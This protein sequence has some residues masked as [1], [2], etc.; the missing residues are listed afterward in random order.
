MDFKLTLT[1]LIS[2]IFSD[3][4]NAQCNINLDDFYT[5][6]SDEVQI[7]LPFNTQLDSNLNKYE[8]Q[9]IEF[10][11]IDISKSND[12]K[13]GDDQIFGPYPIGFNFTFYNRVYNEFWISSNG[14]ISFIEPPTT[15]NSSVIPNGGEPYASIMGAWE[16]WNPGGGG[17][18]FFAS[19]PSK[20]V[21]Q[22]FELNSYNCG[23]E[24]DTVGT[25]QIVLNKGTNF[26]DIHTTQK[27]ECTPS[28][29]GIQSHDGSYAIAVDGRNSS[30]WNVQNQSVRFKPLNM[31]YVNWF[32]ELGE[33]IYNGNPLVIEPLESQ[34]ITV[35]VDN[36][37]DCYFSDE[38]NLFVSIPTPNI[39]LNGS[40]LLCD[41]NGYQYQWYLNDEAIEN[42]NA[43]YFI[44]FINGSYT[45]IA[46]SDIGCVQ[47]SNPLSVD[48]AS[49]SEISLDKFLNIY[50][51]P[52]NGEL[53]IH[54]EIDLKLRLYDINSRYLESFTISKDKIKKLNLETGI[55]FLKIYDSDFNFD[56]R[57]IIVQ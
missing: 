33:L 32:N 35:E 54:S 37:I 31:E 49:I 38:F 7:S 24:P 34:Q 21:V 10:S 8:I 19:F 16:D 55:Y 9:E 28:V 3:L 11:P 42:A 43:Q 2:F 27:T 51:Q 45:V 29:Q 50:P 1:I 30:L 36:G 39:E 53:T 4:I 17:D 52:S 12:L 20:L 26:I 15:Y 57:K 41:L 22:Y 56:V 25:F 47:E 13:M 48:F 5:C 14:F 6:T 40:I 44:P 18:I 46:T 23:N